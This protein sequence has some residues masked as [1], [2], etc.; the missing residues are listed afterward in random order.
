MPTQ[1]LQDGADRRTQLAADRT[2]FAAECT[3]AA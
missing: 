3:Y 1:P 2:M